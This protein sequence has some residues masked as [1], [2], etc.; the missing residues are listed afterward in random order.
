V[1]G[2][3]HAAAGAP[4]V[5]IKG[6]GHNGRRTGYDCSGSVA[7][8]LSGAGLWTAGTPVPSDSGVIKQLLQE[9]LIAR[10]AGTAPDQVTLYDDPGVHIFMNIDGRFFGTSDGGSGNPSQTKGGA[11][12]LYDGAPDATDRA[13][14][15]YHVLP[16][17]LKD[18]TTYGH[19]LTFQ[20]EPNAGILDGVSAGDDLEVTYHGTGVGSMTASAIGWVGATTTTGTVTSIAVG[21]SSFTVQAANGQALTFSTGANANLAGSLEVGDTISVTYTQAAGA[22]TA[23]SLTVTATP[24]TSQVSGTIVAIAADLSSFTLETTTGQQM[25]FS[26]GSDTGI[27]SGFQVGGEVQ[28]SYTQAA[29]GADT[30]LQVTPGSSPY[31]PPL[32]LARSRTP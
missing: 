19:S 5:G 28:V 24:V 10:G 15:R 18:Q 7:A 14:K 8:V 31:W 9:R 11:G 29:D 25:T 26:T 12:W 17:V 4:G 6:P 2:G 27:V 3:G 21:G 30:A 22:L 13:F 1:W 32:T 16:S 23:R 20:I